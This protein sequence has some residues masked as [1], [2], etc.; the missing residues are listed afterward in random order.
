MKQKNGRLAARM[1]AVL[2][3][4][5]ISGTLLAQKKVTGTVTAAKSNQPVSFASVTVKGTSIATSTDAAGA[6]TI[7][8]P[9]GKTVLT[10]TS[11]GFADLD[12]TIGSGPV[13]VVLTET[14][15]TL[16]EIVVTGYTAQRKKDITGSVAVVNVNNLK[17]VPSGTTESLLQGQASGVTVINSGSPGEGSNIRIRGITSLGSASPYVVIDGVAGSLHDLDV[18]DIESIQV[19]KDAGSTAIYGILGSNGVIVVTT[20]KGKGKTVLNYDAYIGTQRPLSGNPFHLANT[21]QYAQALW[22]MQTYSGIDNSKRIAAFGQGASQTGPMIPTYLQPLTFAGQADPDLTTYNINSDQITKANQTGTNW[23]GEIFQPALIQS[24]TLSGSAGGEKS[25]YFY[26]IN[27][28]DQEGTLINTYLKRYTARMNTVF[29]VKNNVRIGENAFIF[30]K[31]NPRITNQNEGNAISMVY[32][33]P[34]IIPVYDVEGNYAGTKSFTINNADNPVAMQ[35]RT[36][37]NKGNDWQVNGNVFAEVD[38]FKHLTLRTSFGGTFDNYYYYY[39][40]YTGYENAEGN[41]NANGFT[42][43]AGY[44]SQWL[45]TNTANYSNTFGKHS[46]KVLIGTEAR[47]VYDR[48]L[49]GNRTTYFS[50]DPSFWT[51]NDGTPSTQS[52]SGGAPY[53]LTSSSVFGKVDYAYNDKYLL[54]ATVRNDGV[55]VFYPGHQ[56]GTF[57]SFTAGWRI[58]REDFMKNISWLTDL[59]LRGGWGKAGSYSNTP[60]T[61]AYTLYASTA[62]QSYYPITGSGTASTAGFFPSQLGNQNTT[63]ET[64][65]Q[66]DA[67]IDASLFKGKLDFSFDWYQKKISGLLFQNRSVLDAFIPVA[68]PYING[69]NI[70]NTG[71]DFSA[72]Y[73]A[74]INHDFHLDITGN[75]SHYKSLVSSL[76]FGYKYLDQYS[77]GSSRIGAFTRSQAGQPVGEFFGYQVVGL[78][79][80]NADI[81][82]SPDQSS[83]SPGVGAF[84]YKDANGDGK[85]TTDDRT[86]IGNPNPDFTYGLNISANYKSFDF[87]VFFYGSQGNKVVNYIKYWTDFPEVFEGN[88]TTTAINNSARIVN[89]AGQ[90][91]S[92]ND[93]TAQVANPGAKT[94]VFN[95]T[96]TSSGPSTSGAFNSYYIEDGSYLRCKSLIIGYTLPTTTLKRFGIDKFRVYVQCANLFTITKYTGLDPEL[97]GSD[98]NNNSNFGIDFGNYP[99]NQKN[100]NIGV[101]VSF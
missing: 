79:Q 41:T 23:W 36:A 59:K 31:D 15:S 101:N 63:W 7:T 16:N 25:S 60:T 78:F 8:V 70:Q 67:G 81:T 96:S 68:Q 74:T 1:C 73:H 53:Q 90:P 82:K 10:V 39:F 80:N 11:V 47:K 45:W 9:A 89:S 76:P 33:I 88:V 51:L 84:K 55:S 93:P 24:H 58:S 20:K 97:Q 46:L 12:V 26:S 5:F 95:T 14:T 94:P 42:E 30:Y 43:G 85:V 3:L 75:I 6:F 87:S 29:N 44:N 49:S 32:R 35:K 71:F 40:S 19:L 57:P 27:Y 62:G 54:A 83:L 86:W 52:N 38:L 77:S 64:D 69:G 61:N 13:N 4:I 17:Q 56:Y 18:N 100:Y 22:D 66:T 50:T 72:T 37:N 21:P 48:S 65:I 2:F 34:P 98:L 99:A 28:F 92:V 91:A